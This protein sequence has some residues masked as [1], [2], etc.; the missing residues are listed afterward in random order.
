M[1]SNIKVGMIL[2]CLKCKQ[3]IEL[4]RNTFIIDSFAEYI[5]CPHCKYVIDV[6]YYHAFGEPI[7]KE[8]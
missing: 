8:M 6:Q 4:N 7:E 5:M 2:K 3:P 1:L